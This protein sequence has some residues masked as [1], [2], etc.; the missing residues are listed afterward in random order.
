MKGLQKITMNKDPFE[1]SLDYIHELYEWRDILKPKNV[2]YDV[3]IN[4]GRIVERTKRDIDR[5]VGKVS[6]QRIRRYKILKEEID[7]FALRPE[8]KKELEILNADFK[9][10]VHMAFHELLRFL[11]SAPIRSNPLIPNFSVFEGFMDK[12][13]KIRLD[14]LKMIFFVWHKATKKQKYCKPKEVE[15]KLLKFKKRVKGTEKEY[16]FNSLD[17]INLESLRVK[18]LYDRKGKPRNDLYS[19]LADFIYRKS[20]VE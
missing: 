17:K 11:P 12:I 7:P 14:P 9:T 16:L 10:Q 3:L 13:P 2:R 19:D 8:E 1:L 18:S 6:E 5:V 4:L 15:D 20:F